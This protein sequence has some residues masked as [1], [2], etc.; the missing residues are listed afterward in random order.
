MRRIISLMMVLVLAAMGLAC[1]EETLIQH[2]FGDFNLVF[3]M[4]IDGAVEDEIVPGQTFMIFYQ[5]IVGEPTF[6][7]NLQGQKIDLILNYDTTDPETFASASLTGT[8]RQYDQLGIAYRDPQVVYARYDPIRGKTAL[9]FAFR[10]DLNFTPESSDDYITLYTLFSYVG[11][12][13]F[14]GT[15]IFCLTTDDPNDTQQL[16]DIMNSISWNS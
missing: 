10:M 15:Y 8:M 16:L 2:N 14:D 1:A 12:P 5:D 3:P 11:D 7:K 4:D 9:N 13:A 6:N